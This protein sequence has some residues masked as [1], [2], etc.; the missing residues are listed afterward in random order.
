[1]IS[2]F[3]L[4]KLKSLLEDFYRLTKIRITV[5]DE[6]FHE[7]TAYPEHISP[8]CQIIRTDGVAAA[9]CKHCDEQACMTAA[10]QHKPFTYRCHAGLTES[11]APL[12]MGNLPIGY[13]LFG[14]VFSYASHEEGWQQI[15]KLCQPYRIDKIRLKEACDQQPLI[16]GDFITSATHIL[17][18]VAYYLCLERMVSL[19]QQEL[20]VRI[21]GYISNHFTEDIS[22]AG[23]CQQFCIGKTRLYE[24]I[25]QN[26]GTGLAE[27]IRALRIDKAKELLLGQPE[28]SLADISAQCGFEDYNYFITV[29]KRIVGMPPKSY[30]KSMRKP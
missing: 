19:H 18:A 28:L 3:N 12:F 15:E 22:V 25:R 11:I 16:A 6:N 17:Q 10:R 8:V 23:L 1:M 13:L 24:I 26:Y 27:H 20:P 14:H 9:A 5:F 30:A 21:D 2:T 4:I 7:L 29:F